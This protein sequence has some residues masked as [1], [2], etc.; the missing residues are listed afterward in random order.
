MKMKWLKKIGIT[1][2]VLTALVFISIDRVDES[3]IVNSEPY[4]STL[5]SIDESIFTHVKVDEEMKV[6]WSKVNITPDHATRMAGFMRKN[7]DSVHDSMFVRTM[8]F[9]LGEKKVVWLTY[10]L[11]FVH[12]YLKNA[13]LDEVQKQ[14]LA[15]FVYL[16]AT[17]THHSIGDWGKDPLTR[18]LYGYDQEIFDG[19]IDQGIESIKNAV[20]DV[21]TAKAGYF[22]YNESRVVRN[23]VDGEHGIVDPFIRGFKVEKESGEKACLYTFSAHPTSISVYATFLT[24]DYPA[25]VND[26]LEKDK[27]DFA[28]FT[29]GATASMRAKY[30]DIFD[31]EAIDWFSDR[32]LQNFDHSFD[33]LELKPFME[34]SFGKVPVFFR[35]PN[36]RILDN[37]RIRPW[38]VKLVV[39]QKEPFVAVLKFDN[40]VCMGLPVEFSGELMLQL[41]EKYKQQDIN[42]IVTG[43][44]GNYLG[45]VNRDCYYH[46]EQDEEVSLLNWYGPEVGNYFRTIIEEIVDKKIK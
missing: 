20:S 45:Y 10:D 35:Q 27:V 17:H 34:V 46:T 2:A 31:Y 5:K 24:G 26:R 9:D 43:L 6:G 33:S 36:L 7:F 28:M 42:L 25:E 29:A 30:L 3:P 39:D 19:L 1:L 32:F 41:D 15:D 14:G 8:V 11:I 18:V 13:I 23:R 38:L 16:S 22:R 12:P 44:N 37:W 4:N 40:T 21:E